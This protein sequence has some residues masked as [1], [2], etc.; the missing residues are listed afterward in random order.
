M[1]GA[2][3]LQFI[4]LDIEALR[5]KEHHDLSEI[6]ELGAV[7]LRSFQNSLEPI[8]TFQSFIRPVFFQV[9]RKFRQLTHIERDMLENA[10][11]FEGVIERFREWIGSEETIFIGWSMHDRSMMIQNCKIYGLDSSW[12]CGSYVDL[13]EEAD[14]IFGSKTTTS[15]KW[16]MEQYGIEFEGIRHRALDDALNTLKVLLRILPEAKKTFLAKLNLIDSYQSERLALCD[17][18]GKINEEAYGISF[19]CRNDGQWRTVRNGC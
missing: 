17:H 12:I 11:C 4:L 10:D 8:D 6:V 5:G 2:F 9:S 16:A 18:G 14:Q 15:L 1:K 7:R 3:L 13:Q 19:S